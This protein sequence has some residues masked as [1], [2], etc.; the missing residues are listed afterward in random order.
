MLH[1]MD[2]VQHM[3]EHFSSVESVMYWTASVAESE[4]AHLI[5]ADEVRAVPSAQ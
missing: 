5:D 4:I 3:S 1:L 2:V